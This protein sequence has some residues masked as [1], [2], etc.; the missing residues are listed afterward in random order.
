MPDDRIVAIRYASSHAAPDS[1]PRVRG[2]DGHCPWDP[3]ASLPTTCF[4][5]AGR[6]N[7]QAFGW[8]VEAHKFKGRDGSRPG[9][10]RWAIPERSI[11]LVK[12][13]TFNKG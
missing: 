5:S 1:G 4:G 2:G 12:V 8:E 7:G 9:G 11:T 6:G 3:R 10:D 13:R